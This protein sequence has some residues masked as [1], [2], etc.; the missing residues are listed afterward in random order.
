MCSQVSCKYP[1]WF[2]EELANEEDKERARDGSLSSGEKVNFICSIHGIYKRPVYYR[3]KI[4]TGEKLRGCPECSE[5]QRRESIG[6]TKRE[7]RPE[8]PEWFINELANERDKEKALKKEIKYNDYIQFLCKEHGIYKQRVADHIDYKSENKKQGCPICGHIK[9]NLNRIENNRK[10]RPDYPEWFISDLAKEE[11]KEKA[12]RKEFSWS[13]K[14]VFLCSIHGEY[15]QRIDAHMNTSTFL[16]K[17]GCPICGRSKQVKNRKVNEASN[18]K[19]PE[20][21]INELANEEDKERARLGT[22]V[23]SESLEFICPKHGIYKQN[24][25]NHIILSTKEPR[26]KCPTCM[27]QVSCY[28]EEIYDYLI[29]LGV[30]V[31]KRN[32]TVIRNP[33]SGRPFELDLYIPEKKIAIEYNGSLWHGEKFKIDKKYHHNK[34]IICEQ[35]GIRLISLFDQDWFEKKEL[36]KSYFKDLVTPKT[37]I[38]GR[39]TTVC[40]LYYNDVSSFYE[41]NHLKGNCNSYTVSYG[42]FYNG[43]LVSAMSF[44][45]PKFGNQK[46]IEWDLSRYCVKFGYSVIG[47]AEK[48]YK[49]FLKDHRPSTIVTYS[50]CDYFSGSVYSKLGFCFRGYTDLPYYW[51]KD[52]EFFPRQKCQ[53]RILKE[54]YP[55]FYNEAITNNASNKEEYIMHKLGFYKVYRCGNKKWIWN[56]RL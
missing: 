38:Y 3:I 41:E 40:E 33:D 16:P 48:L 56:N 8:Y 43:E 52:N 50:D 9:Q 29:S 37:K 27:R 46:D 32:R 1:E 34:F 20:W 35:Q 51:A 21:F 23:V 47:G 18:R 44:S 13:D 55:E 53:V 7:N 15:S 30:T 25:S 22:I 4:S 39:K 6:K 26:C 19:Y 24:V 11:D 28:E 45:K 10:K 36:I 31:E 54:K 14:V 42:L 17:Q 49:V 2:I 5:I 12:K